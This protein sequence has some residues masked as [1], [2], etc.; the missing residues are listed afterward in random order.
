MGWR[1]VVITQ[2]AYLSLGF[3]ALQIRR[4]EQQLQV[5]LED[6][7]VL[8]ID[9]PQVTLTT[10]LLTACADKQICLITVDTSHLPNGIYLPFLSHSRALKIMRTQL[11]L[12][13]PLRKRLHQQLVQQKIRN[14]AACLEM[15]GQQSQCKHLLNVAQRVR[16]GDVDNH[17]AQAAQAYFQALFDASFRR[18]DERPY[19]AALNYGYAVVRA[20]IARSLVSYGFQPA[21]GLFHNS[22]QNAFNLADDVIEPYRAFVDAWVLRHFPE[23]AALTINRESKALLVSL[24]HEDTVMSHHGGEGACTL[25]AAIEATIMS[26]GRIVQGSKELLC[27]P[28]LQATLDRK[29]RI[30]ATEDSDE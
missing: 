23:E 9:H 29:A 17:E 6:V 8:V 10:Q 13:Q 7:S 26:L 25:L 16:S 4:E 18:R 12:A 5:P 1:S 27:L 2:P 19:N 11:E 24:L 3:N 30:S 21:F 22:E 15:T 14:Q 28:L 20:A